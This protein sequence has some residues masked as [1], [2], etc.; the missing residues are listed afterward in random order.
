MLTEEENDF[1]YEVFCPGYLDETKKLFQQNPKFAYYTKAETALKIIRNKE[2]WFR[3]A[4]VMNDRTE[5]SYGL[6]LIKKVLSGPDGDKFW[7]AIYK[8]FN[9]EDVI[10]DA[11]KVLDEW[12]FDWRFETYLFC[13]SL[14]DQSENKTGRL[15]MWRAYGDIALVFAEHQSSMGLDK[16]GVSSILVSYINEDELVNR[17]RR[18]TY[19]IQKHC[20]RLNLLGKEKLTVCVWFM[21]LLY[22]IGTKHPGFS[23]E[24]EVR[25]YFRP[26]EIPEKIMERRQVVINEIPQE[27]W[28]FPL[29][30][31]PEI[32]FDHFDLPSILDRI[33]IGPTPYPYVSMKTFRTELNEAGVN[34]LEKRVVLSDIPLRVDR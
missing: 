22:A 19:G 12:E 20:E 6:N 28:V 9:S 16:L 31:R 21:I 27:I 13:G 18:V 30:N 26:N 7:E 23:E 4:V 17:L 14:H 25:L 1:F 10:L 3:N 8:V 34:N 2:I 32:G 15:S 24:K 33:I 11:T 5:I 29:V